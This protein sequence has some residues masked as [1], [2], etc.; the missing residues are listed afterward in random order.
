MNL[1]DQ[2]SLKDFYKD[3]IKQGNAKMIFN[4]DEENLRKFILFQQLVPSYSNKYQQVADTLE[5]INK[6]IRVLQSYSSNSIAQLREN[7]E[8]HY[9]NRVKDG[10]HVAKIIQSD[11]QT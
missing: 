1:D 5:L 4:L 6:E 3:L 2:E 11:Q 10:N 8:Q 9:F 7:L